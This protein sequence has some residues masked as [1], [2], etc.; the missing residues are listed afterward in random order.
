MFIIM[1]EKQKLREIRKKT[2]ISKLSHAFFNIKINR[3]VMI[4]QRVV[5]KRHNFIFKGFFII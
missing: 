1:Y 2:K 5:K 4:I 3:A